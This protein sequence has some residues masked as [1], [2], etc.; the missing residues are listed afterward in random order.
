[1]H[2]KKKTDIVVGRFGCKN[3]Q[4]K[5]RSPFFFLKPF[6]FWFSILGGG[7]VGGAPHPGTDGDL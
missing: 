3:N 6:L 4:N 5:D 7:E 2:Y 1:M